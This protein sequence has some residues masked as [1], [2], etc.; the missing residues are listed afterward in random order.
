MAI[1]VAQNRMLSLIRTAIE[2]ESEHENE[3]SLNLVTHSFVHAK[4]E[5]VLLLLLL[6]FSS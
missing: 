2:N 6:P 1:C 4:G 3:N 5:I